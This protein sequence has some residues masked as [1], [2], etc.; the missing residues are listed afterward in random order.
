MIQF[1]K[2]KDNSS[3]GSDLMSSSLGAPKY[4]K[5]QFDSSLKMIRLAIDSIPEDYWHHHI[6]GWYYSLTLYH[7]LETTEFYL[8]S[9]PAD[10]KW[11]ERAGYDPDGA[12][13]VHKRVLPLITKELVLQ[14]LIDI[15]HSL[16]AL[17][18]TMTD[19]RLA[20]IDGFEWFKNVFEK[21][22]YLLRHNQHHLGELA[23]V[24][25]QLG[26]SRIKWT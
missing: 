22:L 19:D 15:Q 13:D 3:K 12:E 1:H 7:L 24:A 25:R 6:K 4:L 14:Y 8:A 17:Y 5:R 18:E 16:D 23:L 2:V 10:M 11:G 20:A 21:H 26:S 9:N